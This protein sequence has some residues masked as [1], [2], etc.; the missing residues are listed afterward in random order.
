M[1]SGRFYYTGEGEVPR[2]FGGCVF[3]ICYRSILL[4]SVFTLLLE[5]IYL[6]IGFMRVLF[7][8]EVSLI[9]SS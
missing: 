7:V 5:F 8:F 3:I 2:K 6:A 1:Q 9:P 4:T